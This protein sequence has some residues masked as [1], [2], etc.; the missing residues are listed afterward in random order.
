MS[1]I[2]AL[3]IVALMCGVSHS[4]EQSPVKV[5]QYSP[6]EAADALVSILQRSKS[7]TFYFLSRSGHYDLLP[8]R[9]IRE[10]TIRI[11][12]KCGNNCVSF[13]ANVVAHLRE[14]TAS[15]CQVGQQAVMIEVDR[16]VVLIYSY[17][18]RSIEYE[19]SCFF[20]PDG[21]AS[22]IEKESFIFR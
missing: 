16:G 15:N 1:R 4:A 10:S 5:K 6:A 21:I 18:G 7:V 14:S 3:F 12:R 8:D 13:M 19:G 17:S 22:V 20:N 2:L 11:E 9:F